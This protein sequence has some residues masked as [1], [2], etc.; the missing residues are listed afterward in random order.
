MRDHTA[1]QPNRRV[2]F[3]PESHQAVLRGVA[4]IVGTV[5]PTLGPQPRFV[6]VENAGGRDRAPEL[7]DNAATVARRVIAVAD[8]DAD[9]GAMLVRH[10]LWRQ[11]ERH[12]DGA[13]TAA[14]L[15]QAILAEGLHYIASGGN[16]MALRRHLEQGMRTIQDHLTHSATPIRGRSQVTQ[17][18]RSIC[19][20]AALADLLGEIF[21]IVGEYGYLEIRTGQ[22]RGLE[23]EYVEGLYWDGGLLARS[24]LPEGTPRIDIE[25]AAILITNLDLKDPQPLVPALEMAVRSGAQGLIITAREISDGISALL[26]ANTQPER[27][28][29]IAVKAPTVEVHLQA[30]TVLDLALVTGGRAFV[31]DAG[32]SLADLTPDQLGQA[33]R[34]WADMHYFGLNGGRGDPRALRRRVAELRRTLHA[35]PYGEE[36]ER[37]RKRIGKL[38]GGTAILHVGGVHEL[39]AK[40]R[41]EVAE[42]TAA[43]ARGAL[44]E[45]V[46]PGGGAALLACRR[47]CRQRLSREAGPDER[48]AYR[49]L[50]TALA[51]PL[52]AIVEN[53]GYD[54][55]H[56]LAELQDAEP[57]W[58]FDVESGNVRNMLEAGIVDSV[59]VQQA[60]IANAISTA[61]LALTVDILVHRKN[62]EAAFNT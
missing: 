26:L 52:R 59:A 45:G 62:P 36:Q 21:D 13:A 5:R 61:A 17:L 49:I 46:V 54:A 32:D 31:R 33:R 57:G 24:M 25:N 16:A 9:M 35:L 1:A 14:V 47:L 50:E 8:R 58:G 44:R 3:Q 38:L 39:E 40:A 6:A 34:A 37:V 4:Q 41:Q 55:S 15:F 43:A 2:V 29:A 28:R 12:G 23:R 53:A 60:A 7:L 30:E 18:A 22:G 56:V 11:S 42:R 48:A 10:L 27:F 19:H 51:A 20:D